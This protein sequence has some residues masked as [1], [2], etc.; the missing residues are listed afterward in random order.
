MLLDLIPELLHWALVVLMLAR[1]PTERRRPGRYL[2]H[3]R[4]HLRH[5]S[6]PDLSRQKDQY[7][8][9]FRHVWLVS[10]IRDE[11][12]NSTSRRTGVYRT[13]F[14]SSKAYIRLNEFKGLYTLLHPQTNPLTPSFLRECCVQDMAGGLFKRCLP[15]FKHDV[16][17]HRLS[18]QSGRS[19]PD[20]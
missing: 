2:A 3:R 1:E 18:R 8:A 5:P 9:R 16:L 10:K 4:F 11:A 17:S 6:C 14:C 7:G 15:V 12:L 13:C 20:P 19:F